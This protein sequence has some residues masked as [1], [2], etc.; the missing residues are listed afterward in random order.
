VE[1]NH[2][3]DQDRLVKELRLAGISTIEQANSFLL[4][5]YLPCM[6]RKFSRPPKSVDDAHV[7]PGTAALDDR[8]SIRALHHFIIN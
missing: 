5:T 7:K 3:V 4:E 1:R 8:R 6:N 2:R